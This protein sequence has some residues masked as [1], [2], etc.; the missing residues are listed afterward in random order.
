MQYH[1]QVTADN[2]GSVFLEQLNQN[3]AGAEAGT[4]HEV[5]SNRDWGI[6]FILC[7]WGS[8]WSRPVLFK[9]LGG[10]PDQRVAPGPRRRCTVGSHVL[11]HKHEPL[12]V[13]KDFQKRGLVPFFLGEGKEHGKTSFLG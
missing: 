6:R 5:H 7:S 2:T 11:Q 4:G 12:P 9:P 10:I 3:S 1:K 8:L 13:F